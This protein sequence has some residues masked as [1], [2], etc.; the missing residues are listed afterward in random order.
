MLTGGKLTLQEQGRSDLVEPGK[1]SS[2]FTRAERETLHGQ[3]SFKDLFKVLEFPLSKFIYKPQ[4][5]THLHVGTLAVVTG[6]RD[7]TARDD[8]PKGVHVDQ[9]R[10]QRGAGYVVP[11]TAVQVS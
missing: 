3:S 11:V 1:S 2:R 5:R 6:R 4:Q 8:E 9:S 7:G 10:I